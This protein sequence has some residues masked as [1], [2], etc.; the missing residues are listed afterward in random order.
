[1][2][3]LNRLKKHKKANPFV[4]IDRAIIN[5]SRLSWKAKGLLMY[6]LDQSDEWQFYQ[7]EICSHGPDGRSSVVSGLKELEQCGYLNRTWIRDAKG[8]YTGRIWGIYE[9][10]IEV[11]MNLGEN[12]Q[13][14]ESPNIGN[15]PRC[16]KLQELLG[17]ADIST[18]LNT[19]SH[20]TNRAKVASV[21]KL[22]SLIGNVMP[23]ENSDSVETM[24]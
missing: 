12:V 13:S 9:E 21:L 18:T 17:H 22:N 15:L 10:P 3:V 6:L 24:Y 1:M 11:D 7:T 20:I 19:Y 14:Q 5:D 8:K 4:Q 2:E 23:A 16:R